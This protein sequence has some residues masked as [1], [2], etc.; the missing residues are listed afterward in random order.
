MVWQSTV[1]TVQALHAAF[2]DA[3]FRYADALAS[4]A[5]PGQVRAAV[6][7]GLL[8]RPHRGVLQVAFIS[9]VGDVSAPDGSQQAERHRLES[10]REQHRRELVTARLRLRSDALASTDSAA[11]LYGLARP[12]PGPPPFADFL[13]PGQPDFRRDGLRVRG[14]AVPAW[15]RTEVA[16]IPATSLPRTAVDLAR[17]RRLPDALVPLDSAMRLL[18]AAR[19]G[20]RGNELRRAVRDPLLREAGRGRL[21]AV[22]ESQYAWPGTVA[23]REALDLADP[24][25]ESAAESRGRGWI[26]LAELPPPEVGV[27]IAV[28]SGRCYWVDLLWRA[29]RLIGEVD[30]W[31]KYGVTGDDV[32]RAF[33]AQQERQA[34]LEDEGYRFVR[35]AS[36]DT[37]VTVLAR[38]RAALP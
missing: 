31:G 10:Y 35:W 3:P 13:V 27:P 9:A 12:V 2:G 11:V 5:S 24:A 25:A 38:L 19:T 18:V 8:L 16:G 7:H 34:E 1:R 28:R 21:R 26:L 37:R 6:R 36:T 32:R 22:L 14:S 20:A 4:G 33:R 17:G 29:S 23:V 30:G 15:Q